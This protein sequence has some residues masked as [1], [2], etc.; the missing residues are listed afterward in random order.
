MAY[1]EHLSDRI[2]SALIEKHINFEEKKMMGG[3]VYM[4]EAKMCI[5]VVKDNMM[6]RVGP[7]AYEAALSCKGCREMDFTKR[8]MKGFVFIEPEG[9]D[10]DV[11]LEYWIDLCL[12][13]NPFAK[14][15][16]KK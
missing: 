13:F 12:A 11:D 7:D 2:R 10:M 16:K 3:L 4:V 5:G 1:N 8:P 6:A 15:S 9:W 14:A